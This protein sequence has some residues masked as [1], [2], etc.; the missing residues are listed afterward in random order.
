MIRCTGGIETTPPPTRPCRR[1]V[2]DVA[3]LLPFDI[4][5]YVLI[6]ISMIPII[7]SLNGVRPTA[8][9]QSSGAWTHEALIGF[10]VV[11][12]TFLVIFFIEFVLRLLA[13]GEY[14][15][16]SIWGVID[17]AALWLM[18]IDTTI[19]L[20][21]LLMELDMATLATIVAAFRAVRLIRLF[22]LLKPLIIWIRNRLVCRVNSNLLMG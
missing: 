1:R 4:V 14:Y 2:Y 19:E 12:N 10:I 9:T 7:L 5:F 17:A 21:E 8:W 11:N 3:S 18:I 15:L 20:I 13:F 16:L 6:I 22:R